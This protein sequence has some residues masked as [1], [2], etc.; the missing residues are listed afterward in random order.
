M[1]TFPLWLRSWDS[2]S[3]LD[4]SDEMLRVFEKQM[5]CALALM[6]SAFGSC[7]SDLGHL[8]QHIHAASPWDPTWA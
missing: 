4:L 7:L 6:S 2:E 3:Y 1:Y 5:V 8:H